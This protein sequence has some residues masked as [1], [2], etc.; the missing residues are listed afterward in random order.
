MRQKG[1]STGFLGFS[2][3]KA[4]SLSSAT[5]VGS[6]QITTNAEGVGGAAQTLNTRYAQYVRCTGPRAPT[7]ETFADALF[8][9]NS[10]WAVTDR[11]G[12]EALVPVT[13][14]LDNTID[15]LDDEDPDKASL[16]VFS[17]VQ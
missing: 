14:V 15:V 5:S 7:P 12:I 10:S 9:D 6:K 8:N 16:Q 17:T 1:G 4:T 11:G 2:K 3:K 13:R